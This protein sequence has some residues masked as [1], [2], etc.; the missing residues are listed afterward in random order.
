MPPSSLVHRCL[1][2]LLAGAVAGPAAAQAAA[3][4]QHAAPARAPASAAQQPGD[5]EM[6]RHPWVV[7]PPNRQPQAYFTNL[8][9]GAKVESPFLVRFGLSMRGIVPAGKTAGRAGHH[10]LLVN[11][12]LPLDFK[13]PLPFTDQYIHFGKG[14]M[15]TVL[16]LKPG[17]YT[18][19]LLLADQ[20]HIPFFVYSKPLRVTVTA[21]RAGVTPEQVA[22]AR[23]IELLAPADGAAVR[24]AFRVQFHASGYNVSHAEPKLADTGHFRL[25]LDRGG[26]AEVLDFRD[27]QTEVWLE[28]PTGDYQLRL[29]L[30]ANDT[31]AVLASAAPRKVRAEAFATAS[32]AP[33][34]KGPG[35]AGPAN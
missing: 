6:L 32:A 27:G 34:R 35:G 29:D 13:K 5:P 25:T 14:Q 2:A 17:T 1:A 10:H 26:R 9:D 7:P 30:V 24:G 23:R 4:H 12:P 3:A 18:L 20:G 33:L 21:Q 19:N 16:N 22:G 31:G 15:E 11:Q 28:P 8:A